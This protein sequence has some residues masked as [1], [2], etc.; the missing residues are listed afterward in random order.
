VRSIKGVFA[1]TTCGLALERWARTL[2]DLHESF[3]EIPTTSL[4]VEPDGTPHCFALN[5]VR[6]T[7]NYVVL[8]DVVFKDQSHPTK[9]NND[10]VAKLASWLADMVF[11]N[12]PGWGE[13]LKNNLV[14][15]PNDEFAFFVQHSTEVLTR[16]RLIP[17]TKTVQPGALWTEEHLP[18]DTLLYAPV[19]ARRIMS[20]SNNHEVRAFSL[21][22][23]P[24]EEAV[25]VLDDVQQKLSGILQIGGDET[26][27]CGFARMIW[28]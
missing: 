10:L 19:H 26:T 16:I 20:P 18:E 12:E 15:L 14:I 28:K 9:D 2:K 11:P 8:E 25:K 17:D 21:P 1:W 13:R 7:E 22:D 4:G 23:K 5:G 6:D 27:G 3:P 24:L